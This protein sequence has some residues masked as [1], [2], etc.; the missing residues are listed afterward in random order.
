M[1]RERSVVTKQDGNDLASCLASFTFPAKPWIESVYLVGEFNDW[2][3]HSLP[4]TLSGREPSWQITVELEKG[5][6]YEYAYLVNDTS[7]CVESDRGVYLDH[8]YRGYC[9]RLAA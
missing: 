5:R 6:E 9:S 8:V 1:T 2:D 4:L 7:F 3:Y